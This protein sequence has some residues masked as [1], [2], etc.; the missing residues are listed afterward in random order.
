[1]ADESEQPNASSE[2]SKPAAPNEPLESSES[3]A[4]KER[5]R[6]RQ[7]TL[8]M[9]GNVNYRER[10]SSLR[11]MAEEFIE[12]APRPSRPPEPEPQEEEPE[13][14]TD[15]ALRAISAASPDESAVL[16][17]AQA[18]E[19]TREEPAQPAERRP[20]PTH[21]MSTTAV[22]LPPGAPPLP[23]VAV[24]NATDV[25]DESE[26][27]DA[28]SDVSQVRTWLP[29]APET[30]SAQ[31]L[32][33]PPKSEPLPEIAVGALTPAPGRARYLMQG[34]YRWASLGVLAT[35]A[36]VGAYWVGAGS[37]DSEQARASSA[38]SDTRL[39]TAS[40]APPEPSQAK[41][42]LPETDTPPS[43]AAGDDTQ[44][45]TQVDPHLA[46]RRP[47]SAESCDDVLGQPFEEQS[48]PHP[49]KGG[50]YWSQSRKAL[51]RGKSQSALELMCRS[52]SW[53]PA[54]RGTF[55]LSEYYFKQG[56]FK[57]AMAWAT[58]VPKGSKRFSDAQAMIGDVHSQLGHGEQAL[59]VFVEHWGLEADS[60]EARAELASRF[61]NSA[62]MAQ[63]KKDWWTAE[64]FYRRALALDPE[65]QLAMAGLARA[66]A[67]F[68]LHE[69]TVYWA[70]RALSSD[71]K[72]SQAAIALCES[73]IAR[74]DKDEADKAL[75]RLHQLAPR[76]PLAKLLALRI[77]AL[78]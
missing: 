78:D 62:A 34:G 10:M 2:S 17:S 16:D 39:A 70:E 8:A 21:D 23:F 52:A 35:A 56:D 65:Q 75:D 15:L 28:H 69:A 42:Q 76:H 24:Q 31:L 47:Q 12:H 53:D 13:R 55:G 41:K 1:M 50:A 44:D 3:G 36:A 66:F 33:P 20:Q 51:M 49:G 25:M 74:G 60:A 9:G 48:N 58:R 5:F 19:P 18:P 26:Q 14:L 63:R 22:G 11:E 59:Q 67:H 38:R 29:E 72:S 45:D 71:G 68:E 61:V 54:G 30:F 43:A 27:L 46:V 37:D 64:R 77:R 6:S 4:P 57:Q 7:A 32:N 73:W 40:P